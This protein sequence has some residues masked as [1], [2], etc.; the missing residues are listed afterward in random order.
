MFMCVFIFQ[1]YDKFSNT[2]PL[3]LKSLLKLTDVIAKTLMMTWSFLI[4][5]HQVNSLA[6]QHFSVGSIFNPHSH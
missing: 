3:F 2:N 6:G 1:K 4:S 5:H